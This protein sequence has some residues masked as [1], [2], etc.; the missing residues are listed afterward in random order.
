LITLSPAEGPA[1]GKFCERGEA[2]ELSEGA[3]ERS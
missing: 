2:A 1:F 3:R